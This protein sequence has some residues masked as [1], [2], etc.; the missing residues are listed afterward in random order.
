MK[1]ARVG[2]AGLVVAFLIFF[3]STSPD[4]AAN[5]FHGTW[6]LAANVAHGI[7]DFVDKLAS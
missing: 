5:I 7:R 3:I 6:R 4:A 2:V 1:L